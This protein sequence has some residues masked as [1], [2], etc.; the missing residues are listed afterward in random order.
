MTRRGIERASEGDLLLLE[1]LAQRDRAIGED[2]ELRTARAE[3]AQ[4]LERL[5]KCET[6]IVRIAT[7]PSYRIGRA[8]TALPRAIVAV[9]RKGRE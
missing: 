4:A 3:L 2:V 9:G 7:S 5:E 6:E 8:I 1:A